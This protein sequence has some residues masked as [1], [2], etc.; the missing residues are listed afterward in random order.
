M[1]VLT[2]YEKIRN[3]HT[4]GKGTGDLYIQAFVRTL[5]SETFVVQDCFK[6]APTE[7]SKTSSS[8]STVKEYPYTP[9][10]FTSEHFEILVDLKYP[11]PEFAFGLSPSD[12]S[13]FQYNIGLGIDGN[14]LKWR[15]WKPT[16]ASANQGTTSNVDSTRN[17]YVTAKFV[18]NNGECS[19]YVNDTLIITY[20][21][22]GTLYSNVNKTVALQHWGTGTYYMKN[23][24]VKP[25]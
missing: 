9:F 23:L 11:N 10:Y 6:Y 1:F 2:G 15:T 8:T 12:N 5:Q 20:T 14:T 4:L 16:R 3:V 22:L 24:K 25:L 13:S 19:I 21:G 17:S 7:I 18:Y